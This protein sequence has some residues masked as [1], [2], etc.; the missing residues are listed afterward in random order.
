MAMTLGALGGGGRR[1]R[2]PFPGLSL[3]TRV[4]AVALGATVLSAWLGCELVY[5]V[6][7]AIDDDTGVVPYPDQPVAEGFEPGE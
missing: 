3:L 6:R 4:V 7:Q 1:S 5:Q 2:G